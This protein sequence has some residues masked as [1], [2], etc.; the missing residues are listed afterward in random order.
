MFLH[1]SC[2]FLHCDYLIAH[3][4]SA[5]LFPL[6]APGGMKRKE[7]RGKE[8]R[9]GK[10]RRGEE[11]REGRGKQRVGGR[12]GE[13]QRGAEERRGPRLCLRVLCGSS[14]GDFGSSLG[15]LGVFWE[16][17]ESLWVANFQGISQ[18]TTRKPTKTKKTQIEKLKNAKDHYG[19]ACNGDFGQLCGTFWNTSL[20]P[21]RQSFN[22]K[23][24]KLEEISKNQKSKSEKS[25]IEKHYC[26]WAGNGDLG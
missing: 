11:R 19:W 12:Q 15:K 14:S 23:G 8:G 4:Q 26:G 18:K 2:M 22:G 6:V 5:G 10:E 21:V 13:R 9:R 16:Q 24:N 20:T 1:V 17:L 7:K 25:K 3:A